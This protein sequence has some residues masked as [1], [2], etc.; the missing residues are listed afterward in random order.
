MKYRAVYKCRFCGKEY[1]PDDYV[2]RT[3]WETA[4]HMIERSLQSCLLEVH[5][6]ENGDVG[7]G[8]LIGLRKVSEE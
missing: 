1:E 6:C 3:E 2:Y 7:F 8:D 5:Y 4:N